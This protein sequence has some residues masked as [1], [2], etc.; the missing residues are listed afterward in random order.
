MKLFD[1]PPKKKRVCSKSV[2]HKCNGETSEWIKEPDY[3]IIY[4]VGHD[5]RYLTVFF[6][7]V[8]FLALC[9]SRYYKLLLPLY[10]YPGQ[11]D[12]LGVYLYYINYSGPILCLFLTYYFV[13]FIKNIDFSKY[14]IL[15]QKM[16]TYKNFSGSQLFFFPIITIASGIM[17]LRPSVIASFFYLDIFQGLFVPFFNMTIFVG[18]VCL[19]III[20]HALLA[21]IFFKFVLISFYFYYE[22]QQLK[23]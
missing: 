5:L 8:I 11:S 15:R 13:W 21:Q 19:I 6:G 17:V 9:L 1:L 18:F 23:E 20:L 14:N 16:H 7:A 2:F 10:D 4:R 12:L 3:Y 22:Y